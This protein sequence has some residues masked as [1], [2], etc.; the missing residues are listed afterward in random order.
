MHRLDLNWQF[1]VLL[2]V[3]LL[4]VIATGSNRVEANGIAPNTPNEFGQ[5]VSAAPNSQDEQTTPT[6]SVT[7]IAPTEQSTATF[8]STQEPSWT[9]TELLEPTLTLEPTFEP[10]STDEPTIEPSPTDEPTVEPTAT[11]TESPAPTFTQEPTLDPTATE[12]PF[13]TATVE[14]TGTLTPTE[15]LTPTAT[16]TLLLTETPTP[17]ESSTPTLIPSVD[18]TCEKAEQEIDLQ[19]GGSLVVPN[20]DAKVSKPQIEIIFPEGGKLK[21]DPS[22]NTPKKK[23]GE[24]HAVRFT[25]GGANRGTQQVV[26]MFELDLL[27]AQDKKIK[28]PRFEKPLT[29]IVHY[30]PEQLGVLDESILDL[31]YWDEEQESWIPFYGKLD[32]ANHTLTAKVDHFTQFSLAAQDLKPYIPGVQE[33]QTDLFTGAAT[34]NYPLSVPPGRAGMAPKLNLTYSSAVANSFDSQTQASNVG[35]GWSLETGYIARVVHHYSSS[36]TTYFLHSYTLVLDGVSYE[37]VPGADGHYHTTNESFIRIDKN[38]SNDNPGKWTVYTKDGTKYV[39]GGGAAY[40]TRWSRRDPDPDHPTIQGEENYLWVLKSVTDLHNNEIKYTY[41]KDTLVADPNN[42]A[43]CTAGDYDTAI[44]PSL[45]QYNFEG[46]TPRS[47]L[48]FVYS[49]RSDQVK[50]FTTTQCGRAPYSK[51]KLDRVE[52]RTALDASG[53]LTTVLKYNFT[54]SNG[55]VFPGIPY[56]TTNTITPTL[57]ALGLTRF[58]KESGTNSN[59]QMGIGDFA[60]HQGNSRLLEATNALGGKVKY[61]YTDSNIYTNSTHYIYKVD[62]NKID[63]RDSWGGTDQ[64]SPV[65]ESNNASSSPQ[66]TCFGTNKNVLEITSQ[67]SNAWLGRTIYPF[68]PAGHYQLFVQLE[69]FN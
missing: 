45:I 11:L 42:T 22:S 47:E 8:E 54:T 52:T 13:A 63:D 1:H 6:P 15:S 28:K 26:G 14:V 56:T 50:Y 64:G 25:K 9:P 69:G 67:G 55:A 33:F 68:Q 46:S 66:P 34:V 36:N 3:V 10:T 59:V 18:A 32:L 51:K 19:V 49:T 44:Y 39:F 58:W 60:Y 37:L 7:D 17:T 24:K 29:V 53:T 41:T 16:E 43:S 65:I 20:C 40:R 5:V 48:A 23:D 31:V 12:T 30:T 57:G 61:D 27:N 62:F 21:T 2:F 4:V 38:T 35:V